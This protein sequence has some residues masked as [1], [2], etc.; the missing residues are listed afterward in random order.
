MVENSKLIRRPSEDYGQLAL[1]EQA[2]GGGRWESFIYGGPAGSRRYFVY[3]PIGYTL[4]A[5]VPM[6]VM[7]HGCTQ[8]PAD[9]AAGT[10]WNPLA[11]QQAFIVVYP[12]QTFE[13]NPLSCWDWFLPEHQ[14]RGSGEAGVIGGITQQVIAD[15]TRWNVD[16]ARVYLA[17][18][19]AGGAMAVL[20]GASYP[21]LYAAVAVHSGLE[22][23]AATDAAAARPAMTDGGPDP[24][25]QGQAAFDAMDRHGRSVP[26]IV[27]H[28]TA[29]S[30]VNPINGDQVVRQWMETNR[31]ASNKAYQP[32]SSQPT[33]MI[34]GQIPGGHAYTV[35]TWDD[36]RGNE[37]QEY[38]RITDMDHAWSGGSVLGS[39]TDPRGPDAT[40]AIW[41][42]FAN[43]RR[44]P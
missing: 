32:D 16:P 30:V 24:V 42:F 9:S 17:G 35:S 5:R 10:A 37:I 27:F 44:M 40:R 20:L 6:V 13:D 12:E 15:D 1:H 33:K 28:G 23:Q 4:E 19:S 21:D 43:H 8:T 22:Y 14:V 11:D 31:L 39:F 3:T 25:R 29:D 34:N 41:A 2:R 36:N 38:W 7:L 26:S 18:M